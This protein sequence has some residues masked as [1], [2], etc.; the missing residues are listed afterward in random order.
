MNKA[1]ALF[2][3]LTVILSLMFIVFLVLDQFNPMMNFIDNSISRWLLA[4]SA[5]GES[6]LPDNFGDPGVEDRET[7]L[8]IA[9]K[10]ELSSCEEFWRARRFIAEELCRQDSLFN[11]IYWNGQY[12]K[13]RELLIR[14]V[15]NCNRHLNRKERP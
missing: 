2:S 14:E 15:E 1:H 10:H 4:G 13:T 5:A 12:L 11:H 3:H 7:A 8:Q 6:S 9:K